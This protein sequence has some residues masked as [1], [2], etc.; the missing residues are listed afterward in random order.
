MEVGAYNHGLYSRFAKIT[1]KLQCNLGSY[2]PTHQIR[3]LHL[4]RYDIY[5]G[6]NEPSIPTISCEVTWNTHHNRLG[7]WLLLHSRVLGELTSSNGDV[8]KKEF[9]FPPTKTEWTNQVL[10]D[11]LR[12]CVMEFEST[13][14]THLPLIELA[15]NNNYHSS[16]G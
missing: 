2:G 10:E 7:S 16:L 13:W 1:A 12:A 8:I 3:S 14:E 5:Y 9:G 15:Y 11:M 6:E 4:L